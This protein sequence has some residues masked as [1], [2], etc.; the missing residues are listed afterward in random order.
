MARM[1][2]WSYQCMPRATDTMR[3][4][5]RGSGR[6][7]STPLRDDVFNAL[8]QCLVDNVQE[9]P[10]EICHRHVQQ[11]AGPLPPGFSALGNNRAATREGPGW[12]DALGTRSLAPVLRPTITIMTRCIEMATGGPHGDPTTRGG[13][14]QR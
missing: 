5:P 4:S 8:N 10:G 2:I 9:H 13:D 12:R 11:D 6:G 14:D 3:A 1:A 7:V